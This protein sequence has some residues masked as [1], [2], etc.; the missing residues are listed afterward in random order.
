MR[1]LPLTL[2]AF[3]AFVAAYAAAVCL[4]HDGASE[5]ALA[6]GADDPADPTLDSPVHHYE[7]RASWARQAM[8]GSS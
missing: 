2:L 5:A 8:F 4:S 1:R 6:P 7:T 3:T